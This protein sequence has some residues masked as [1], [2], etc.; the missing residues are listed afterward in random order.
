MTTVSRFEQPTIGTTGPKPRQVSLNPVGLKERD[1]ALAP[2]P[3]PKNAR[4]IGQCIYC[5]IKDIPLS[6]EHAV[7]FGLHGTWTLLNASCKSCADK[8]SFFE[9]DTL[10]SLYGHIRNVLAMRTRHRK[11]RPTTL[12]LIVEP[13]KLNSVQVPLAEFPLHLPIPVFAPPGIIM[14]MLPSPGII[15][16]DIKL[17][18]IAGPSFKATQE[19][20]GREFAG[21]HLTFSPELFARTLAKIAYCVGIYILGLSPFK[22]SPV[23]QIILG[24]NLCLGHWIGSWNGTAMNNSKGPFAAKV[25]ANGSEIHVVLRLFAQFNTPEYH[26]VLGEADPKF[27]NSPEWPWK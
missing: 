8:T 4:D 16:S 17:L 15:L 19:R 14:N 1:K 27:V 2:L 21:E 22:N 10:S 11:K 24:E 12:P 3:I 6:T 5:G 20:I 13:D 7:P 25:L 18:H 26:V 9:K 23:R